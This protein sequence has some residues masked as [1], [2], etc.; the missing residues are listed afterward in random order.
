MLATLKRHWPEYL[1][2]AAGLGLLMVVAGSAATLLEHPGS[3]LRQAIQE[4]VLRRVPMGLAM[5][6]TVVGMVYSPWGVRSGAHLN[7]A[8]TLTFFLLGK[9][10]PRDG[11]YYALAQLGGALAGLGLVALALG[12]ALGHPAVHYVTT[13]PRP[14]GAGRAFGAP[15]P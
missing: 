1:C 13:T 2:E 6:L 9:I 7:P 15:L 3:P 5:G 4:P 10:G 8:I 12:P 11:A 14:A